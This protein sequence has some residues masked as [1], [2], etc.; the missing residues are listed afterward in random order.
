MKKL[1]YIL[2]AITALSCKPTVKKLGV[3]PKVSYYIVGRLKT[4]EIDSSNTPFKVIV[5]NLN[6]QLIEK[7]VYLKIESSEH[8]S[9]MYSLNGK[10]E[11]NEYTF[12]QE[13]KNK[14]IN[15]LV[16]LKTS[17]DSATCENIKIIDF[18]FLVKG[19]EK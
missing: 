6:P 16:K 3:N 19:Q 5:L 12:E 9:L 8:F 15:L 14:D 13:I 7:P 10:E 11:R 1:L 2:I 17:I 18:Q 4:A